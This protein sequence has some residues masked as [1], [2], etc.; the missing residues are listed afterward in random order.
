MDEVF[1]GHCTVYRALGDRPKALQP[2][3][4]KR[5][6]VMSIRFTRCPCASVIPHLC[7]IVIS[8]RIIGGQHDHVGLVSHQSITGGGR[9]ASLADICVWMYGILDKKTHPDWVELI[10]KCMSSYSQ[11]QIGTTVMT[12][13]PDTMPCASPTRHN[14]NST[15]NET[16]TNGVQDLGLG[17]GQR[18]ELHGG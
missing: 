4:R 8:V 12:A 17:A 16:D 6:T 14:P 2:L 10:Q 3:A 7:T 5:K 9:V 18:S 13:Q 11:T 15:C 1:G